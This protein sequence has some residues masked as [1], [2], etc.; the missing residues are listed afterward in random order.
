MSSI[1][2]LIILVATLGTAALSSIFGMVGGLILMGVLAVLLPVA[3]AMVLHGIIQ[4]TSNGYRA[5]LNRK[6]I[7]WAV[8]IPFLLGGAVAMIAVVLI[9]YTPSPVVV[10]FGLGILPFTAFALPKKWAL[11]ITKP[12]VAPLAGC[13]VIITNL[14]A[15]VGGP[16]LDIFFQDVPFTRHQV[17]ATK[18]VAQAIGHA[19]KVVF[20]TQL[21]SNQT[22]LPNLE[23]LLAC[24]LIS[25][26]GTTLGKKVL[27]QMQDANFF[28][29]TQAILLTVGA[30][31]ILRGFLLLA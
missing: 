21:L 7:Q 12:V 10:F 30:I 4:L 28:K 24:I 11:D 16:I 5:Y 14:L 25:M 31:Y 3:Q 26:L 22:N 13:V 19:T 1:T 23:I 17:V 29:W 15:G 18:A 8:T 6:D 9:D 27:D 2:I 20:Y